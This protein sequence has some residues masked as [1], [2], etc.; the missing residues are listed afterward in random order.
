M[1]ILKPKF[2]SFLEAEGVEGQ[3]SY[4]IGNVSEHVYF[5][6]FPIE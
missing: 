1:M 3:K 2:F 6:A 5:P 4:W